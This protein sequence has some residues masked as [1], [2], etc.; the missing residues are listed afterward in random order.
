M[1]KK[2]A[3]EPNSFRLIKEQAV[4]WL[5]PLYGPIGHCG[6]GKAVRLGVVL[7]NLV[8]Q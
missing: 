7:S 5:H 4:M 2:E 3:N 6:A 8:V 1:C